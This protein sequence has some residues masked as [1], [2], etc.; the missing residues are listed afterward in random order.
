MIDPRLLRPECKVK[1]IN[2]RI[3]KKQYDFLKKN[4]IMANKLFEIA[5][6]DLM[7]RQQLDILFRK[8]K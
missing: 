8:E 7:N 2:M 4:K 5:V 3:T 6:D 1:K